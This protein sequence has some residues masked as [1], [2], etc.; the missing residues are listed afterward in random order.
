MAACTVSG[1]IGAAQVE[2]DVIAAQAA[3]AQV[4]RAVAFFAR[5]QDGRRGLAGVGGKDLVEQLDRLGH[6]H[7]GQVV[8]LGVAEV[9]P[10]EIVGVIGPGV[11]GRQH[12]G[13]GHVALAVAVAGVAGHAVAVAPAQPGI[14]QVPTGFPQRIVLRLVGVASR[15]FVEQVDVQAVVFAH[16]QPA[17]APGFVAVDL[18]HVE[19][20]GARAVGAGGG[21]VGTRVGDHL[22]HPD[23][24]ILLRAAPG[25]GPAATLARP[26]VHARL[27]GRAAAAGVVGDDG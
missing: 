12:I 8:L 26:V 11:D 23:E 24:A 10:S 27:V 20:I 4:A 2:G 7:V 13:H 22:H 19:F 3:V 6:H 17:H 25:D 5:K 14:V 15:V 18:D 21:R 9:A 16:L 1:G